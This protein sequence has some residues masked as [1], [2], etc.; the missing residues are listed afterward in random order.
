M[1]WST[2]FSPFRNLNVLLFWSC[3][4]RDLPKLMGWLLHLMLLFKDLLVFVDRHFVTLSR[5]SKRISELI[6]SVICTLLF[7]YPLIIYPIS[8]FFSSSQYVLLVKYFLLLISHRIVIVQCYIPGDAMS[9]LIWST[10]GFPYC[11]SQKMY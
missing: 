6:L 7:L 10:I 4:R 2:S 5:S 1:A 11:F 8:I 9:F 3:C